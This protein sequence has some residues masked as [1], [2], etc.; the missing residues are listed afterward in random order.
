M[1]GE[2][3]VS[4]YPALPETPLISLLPDFYSS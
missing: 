1:F 2:E 4:A 3:Q